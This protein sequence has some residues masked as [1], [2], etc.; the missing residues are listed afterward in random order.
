M[1]GCPEETHFWFQGKNHFY[2]LGVFIAILM[3]TFLKAS[4]DR[5]N[6]AEE[7]RQK[8]RFLGAASPNTEAPK[9]TNLRSCQTTNPLQKCHHLHHHIIISMPSPTWLKFKNSPASVDEPIRKCKKAD[10]NSTKGL[11]KSN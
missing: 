11:I 9:C 2:R 6:I 8:L 1:S 5:L 3:S 10:G 7:S 4:I